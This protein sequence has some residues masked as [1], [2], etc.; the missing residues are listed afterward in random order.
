MESRRSF[1][2]W[3]NEGRYYQQE[4]D[5]LFGHALSAVKRALDPQ[6]LLNPGVL[7]AQEEYSQTP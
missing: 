6:G 2:G 1:W 5:P 4:R 3:G 7:L